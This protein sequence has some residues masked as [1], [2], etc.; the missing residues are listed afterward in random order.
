MDLQSLLEQPRLENIPWTDSK[1]LLSRCYIC[2]GTMSCIQEVLP[3][4]QEW[5]WEVGKLP[6][7]SRGVWLSAPIHPHGG[8]M[9]ML[10]PA[11]S[12]SVGWK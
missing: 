7:S 2:E 8:L 1:E 10:H 9:P 6:L 4:T 3:G 5:G 11:L 12:P